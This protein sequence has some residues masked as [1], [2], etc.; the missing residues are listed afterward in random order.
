MV[1]VGEFAIST[2]TPMA[3]SCPRRRIPLA[4]GVGFVIATGLLHLS[5]IALGSFRAGPGRRAR[6]W[7]PDRLC[8]LLFLAGALVGI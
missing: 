3:S 2:D 8:R 1:L 5:G 4:Y 7:R 6:R